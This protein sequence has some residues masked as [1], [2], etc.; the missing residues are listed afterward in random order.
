MDAAIYQLMDIYLKEYT[1]R[2]LIKKES[3]IIGMVYV[4]DVLEEILQEK[5]RQLK[6]LNSLVN[7][8][9]YKRGFV[10]SK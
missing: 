5:N 4:F 1:R 10:K 9:Y 2:I 3:E 8:E 6:E 7:L